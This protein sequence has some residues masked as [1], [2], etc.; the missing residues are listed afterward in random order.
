MSSSTE[1]ELSVQHIFGDHNYIV[2]DMLELPT[3]ELEDASMHVRD[4]VWGNEYIGDQPYDELL[5]Q[6]ARSPL[7]R[8]LQAVE[9]LTLPAEYTTVP[10][11]SSFS[12]WQHVWGSLVFVRKM[13]E[14]DSRYS[15]K[16]RIVMQLRTLFSDV[17]QTAFSHL[18]DWIFQSD[19]QSEDL[20]DQDLRSL[21]E[22]FQIG[23]ML[24]KYDLTLDETVFP[25]TEDWVECP[26]PNL[27]VDRVDY[28]M[29]EVLRWMP[30]SSELHMYRHELAH[31]QSL[32]TINDDHM[33]EI[34][35]QQFAR[36]F[37]LAYNL[38]PTEHWA[39]PVHRL[40]LELLQTAVK[41]A[42]L[43]EVVTDYLFLEPRPHPRDMMY[44]IDA[45]FD[46]AFFDWTGVRL[47]RLM[48][49]IGLSQREIF[50]HARQSE[51]DT[52]F[53][54]ASGAT[55]PDPNTPLSWRGKK[56][57]LVAPSVELEETSD[58][59][60]HTVSADRHGLT[61]ILPPLKPR[62]IDP[63]VSTPAGG[64]PLSQLDANFNKYR[65]DQATMTAKSYAAT[66]LVNHETARKL[67]DIHNHTVDEWHAATDRPR[68]IKNLRQI[69]TQAAMY[70]AGRRFDTITDW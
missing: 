63:L 12:R 11:T 41:R 26:S 53:S 64:I 68:N 20:H 43:D 9:Q 60:Q 19:A 58:N 7:F 51:L 37:A 1:R 34:S 21:L 48:K 59:E 4:V 56:Y 33:L 55:F 24:A 44:G 35:D 36:Q 2:K 67:K 17:G 66:L 3:Y 25:D 32:F 57:G 39:Q 5:M 29:R 47:S 62:A 49:S 46:R 23:D 30:P 70:A 16:D 40:Q 14:G 65:A 28:G 52:I 18:G 8:R 13:T 15:E 10:N 50:S 54:N 69:V 42:L 31:P 22:T 61:Y 38:L 27:C 6:L 45:N